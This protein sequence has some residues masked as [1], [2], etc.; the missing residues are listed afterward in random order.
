MTFFAACDGKNQL[1]NEKKALFPVARH[2][3]FLIPMFMMRA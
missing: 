1:V 2:A 3:S